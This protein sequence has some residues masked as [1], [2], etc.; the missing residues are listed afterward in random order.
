VPWLTARGAAKDS[1]PPTLA[2]VNADPMAKENLLA[3]ARNALRGPSPDSA[4]PNATRV[5]SAPDARLAGKAVYSIAIQMPNVTSFSGSWIVWFSERQPV[6]GAPPPEVRA[7][8]PLRKVDPKYVAEAAQERI[9]GTVRLF[10]LIRRDGHVESVS[11][12][13]HLDDRLDKSAQDALSKW[14]FEP[15]LRNGAPMDIEAV[16]EIPF[17]LAPRSPR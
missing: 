4:M 16:F 14:V 8:V 10:A 5:S 9:E 13:R 3:A 12:L 6:P 7:P 2:T 17:H 15:A 11:L 1:P